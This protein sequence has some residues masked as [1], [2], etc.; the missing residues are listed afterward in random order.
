MNDQATLQGADLLFADEPADTEAANELTEVDSGAETVDETQAEEETAPDETDGEA[1]ESQDSDGEAEEDSEDAEDSDD[2]NSD[3]DEEEALYLDLDGEDFSLDEVRDWRK[4]HEIQGKVTQ[5]RMEDAR[6]EKHNIANEERITERLQ[7]TEAIT[8]VVS[9][10]VDTLK[11]EGIYSDDEIKGFEDKVESLRAKLASDA[12]ADKESKVLRE[13]R[14]LIK[15]N[16]AWFNEGTTEYTEEGTKA[17]KLINDY[18]AKE[19]FTPEE[20][21]VLGSF[22]KVHM[23]LHKSAQFDALKKKTVDLKR[24]VKKVPVTSKPKAKPKAPTKPKTAEES[25]FNL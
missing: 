11:S 5:K 4:A 22:H 13:Q 18:M 14:L 17:Y 19:Q 20:A 10:L 12:E 24:K 9:E 7:R 3:N 8:S 15:R 21:G 23:L 6:R 25:V 1:E 2:D 16:K